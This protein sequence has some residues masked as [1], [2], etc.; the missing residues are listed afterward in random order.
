MNRYSVDEFVNQTQQQDRGQGLFEL[1]T[2]R[3][4][5]LNLNGSM[6][7][8]MGSMISYRGD[9]KFTREGILEQGVGNLWRRMQTESCP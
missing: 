5:E 6:W 4:L 3:I 2:E 1:E 7:T 9:V 8:K